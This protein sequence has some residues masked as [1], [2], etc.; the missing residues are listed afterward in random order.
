MHD[1]H[2]ADIIFKTILENAEKNNLKNVNKSVIELGSVVEHGEEVLPE[3]L[4]FNIKMMSQGTMAEGM[5]VEVIKVVGDSWNL[6]EIEGDE[7]GV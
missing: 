6:R 5:E 3:N 1:F 4:V 2:L 7:E